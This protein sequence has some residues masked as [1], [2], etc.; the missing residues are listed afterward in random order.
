MTTVTPAPAS[1]SANADLTADQTDIRDLARRV[2]T[3]RVAPFAAEWDRE[4]TFPRELF[5]ELGQLGLLAVDL[6]AALG[7]AEAGALAQA[8]V[9]EELARA[10]AGVGTSLVVHYAV[11]AILAA[12]CSDEQRARWFPALADGSQLCA[13][14]LTEADAGSD[15][16][17]IRTRASGGRITGTKQWCTTGSHAAVIAVIAKDDDTPGRISAFLVEPGADGF[18]VTREE[19]K[20]GIRSSNTADLSFD[21]TPGEYLGEPGSGQRM[22]LA[23]LGGGRISVAALATGIGQAA[24]DVATRYARERRAFGK[25]I[26][27]HQAIA[28][29]LADMATDVAAARALTHRAARLKE[30]GAPHVIEASQAKLFA[31]RVARNNAQ[32]AIQVLGGYGFS[33]DFPAEKLYRDAK[34]TEIYEGTSEIQRLV[35]SRDLLGDLHV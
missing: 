27:A 31:S 24:L 21:G 20:L 7:G 12:N 26:G 2:A 18:A 28:H 6:P 25:P 9:L 23:G 19:D 34:I 11:T 8:L 35:I 33:R 1:A 16:G 13:F 14:A 22:A 17:A 10:D 32:E 4:H 5:T 30:A 3:D 29:K 15:T